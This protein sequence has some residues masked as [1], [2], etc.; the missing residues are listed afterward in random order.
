MDERTPEPRKRQRRTAAPYYRRAGDPD[1]ARA[2]FMASAAIRHHIRESPETLGGEPS[3]GLRTPSEHAT[4]DGGVME[5]VLGDLLGPVREFVEGFGVVAEQDASTAR[6]SGE[7]AEQ[8]LAVDRAA[9]GGGGRGEFLFA[10][11]THQRL[12]RGDHPPEDLALFAEAC[13][14]AARAGREVDEIRRLATASEFISLLLGQPQR[15]A[16]FLDA[17]LALIGP[18]DDQARVRLPADRA[19]LAYVVARDVLAGRWEGLLAAAVYDPAGTM[20]ALEAHAEAVGLIRQLDEALRNPEY[21]DDLSDRLFDYYLAR[22]SEQ[23]EV[24]AEATSALFYGGKNSEEPT[25][26]RA[27][28]GP[29]YLMARERYERL[30]DVDRTLA[31]EAYFDGFRRALAYLPVEALAISPG[32]AIEYARKAAEHDG[33]RATPK[34]GRIKAMSDEGVEREVGGRV[35]AIWAPGGSA[36]PSDELPP[37][38]AALPDGKLFLRF[39]ERR[40][41]GTTVTELAA[42]LGVSRQTIYER[43]KRFKVAAGA[44]V[45]AGEPVARGKLARAVRLLRDVLRD[46]PKLRSDVIEAAASRGVS[47]RTLDRAAIEIGVA[48]T[49]ARTGRTWSLPT[50]ASEGGPPI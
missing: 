11:A 27:P 43:A 35:R 45:E 42:E 16:W 12:E 37:H 13:L 41:T 1:Y 2:F 18:S 9:D 19:Y 34:L 7:A 48:A 5:R 39:A 6:P 10:E 32:R 21:A 14:R 25:G 4:D 17:Y 38:L 44:A 26:P 23:D 8:E 24:I 20:I 22:R 40:A 28:R 30:G 31:A 15:L 3:R 49:G 46:G 33:D 29:V 47:E 36:A 50:A